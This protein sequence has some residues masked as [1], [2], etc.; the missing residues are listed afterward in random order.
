[1]LN[2]APQI[3]RKL[4]NEDYA[5]ALVDRLLRLA[6]AG[7]SETEHGKDLRAF[8]AL[9]TAGELTSA[10]AGWTIRH[11]TGLAKKDLEF[12][13]LQPKETKKHPDNL[14]ARS[15]VDSHEH[16]NVGTFITEGDKRRLVWKLLINL[17]RANSGGWP[18]ELVHHA[19]GALESLEFGEKPD[20][21]WNSGFGTRRGGKGSA[22][23]RR[24]GP[25]TRAVHC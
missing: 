20:A 24:K 3:H 11:A 10:M 17:L 13:T 5:Q 9:H 8:D 16:E 25:G 21:T 4:C 18:W 6:I 2:A 7:G 15:A 1:M 19:I 22:P 23:A 12:V 14:S